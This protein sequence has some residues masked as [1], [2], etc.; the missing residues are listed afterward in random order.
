MLSH[1]SLR[2]P[3]NTVGCMVLYCNMLTILFTEIIHKEQT[4]N[5]GDIFH[6]TVEYCEKYSST[7][8]QLAHRGWHRVTRQ[9]ELLSAGG[10]GGGEWWSWRIISSRTHH[11]T[12][13]AFAPVSSVQFSRSFMSDSLRPH[14]LSTAGFCVHHQLPEFT[15]THVL[16]VG[17]A[18]QPSHPLSS[19]SST[20]NLSQHQGLF[21][22]VS[23][24]HQVAKV[25]EFQLQYQTG[26][27]RGGRKW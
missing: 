9:E 18:I 7:V 14:G 5:K 2:Y 17:D 16:W 26:G 20:F 11:C 27:G 23:S 22:W 13:A 21:Q 8:Q 15:Q 12:I 4:K 10:R 24:S 25:S 3:T 19:P 6:L 1:F